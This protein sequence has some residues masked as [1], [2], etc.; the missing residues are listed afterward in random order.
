MVYSDCTAILAHCVAA[1][2][3]VHIG[4]VTAQPCIAPG[5]LLQPAVEDMKLTANLLSVFKDIKIQ[6]HLLCLADT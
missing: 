2:A 4:N 1:V 3:T 6:P 5:I